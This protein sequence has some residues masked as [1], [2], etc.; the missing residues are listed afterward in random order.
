M[1]DE[2]TPSAL[3]LWLILTPESDQEELFLPSANLEKSF[4]FKVMMKSALPCSEQRQNGSSLG[5][6]EISTVERALTSS[7]RSRIKLTTLPSGLNEHGGA[8]ELPCILPEC[9]PL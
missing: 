9:L 8:S 2:V 7:A 6:D 1:S 3:F 4:G 5:S